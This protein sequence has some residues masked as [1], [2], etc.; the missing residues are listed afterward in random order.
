MA[1]IKAL[2]ELAGIQP[3]YTDVFGVVHEVPESTLLTL[4]SA[5]GVEAQDEQTRMA[6][7]YALLGYANRPLPPVKILPQLRLRRIAVPGVV[8]WT[9]T[10]EED[11]AQTH[12]A[13]RGEIVLPPLRMGYY[14]LEARLQTGETYRSR[15]IVTPEYCWL[16]D[17]MHEGK[18]LWGLAAQLYGVRSENN[19][20]LGDFSDLTALAER[21][22]EAGADLVGINPIHAMYPCNEYHFSP[23]SPSSRLYINSLYIDPR[24][25][26]GFDTCAEAQRIWNDPEFQ[27]RLASVRAAELV[28][29]PEIARL[30]YWLLEALYRHFQQHGEREKFDAYCEEQGEL[31]TDQALF[32]A[33]NEH[34]ASQAGQFKCWWEWPEDYRSA[35]GEAAQTFA[36]DHAGRLEYFRW[37][38]WVA[39]S[40]MRNAQQTARKN[41]M[42]LGL[43]RDLAVGSDQAGAEVWL[44][45]DR[46]IRGVAVGAPPDR[47]NPKGQNW[48]LPP[49]N[50]INLREQGYR[51]FIQLV[52]ANM[53]HCRALR[54][55]HAFG[56]ARLFLIPN[57]ESPRNGAYMLFNFEEM[58]AVLRLESHR[59]KCV[60]IGEDLGTF[61]PNYKDG[62]AA[63]GLLSYRLLY[64]ERTEEQF[65]PPG[66]YPALALAT[67]STHDLPTL[68]GW[69]QEADL[70]EREELQLYPTQEM[71]EAARD[72]RRRTIP[73][74]QK[75]LAKENLAEADAEPELA[76]VQ[77]YLARSPAGIIMMQLE[78]LL[79]VVRQA[80][81]PATT[82]QRPNWRMRL[83]VDLD[84]I[85]SPKGALTPI[86]RTLNEER[87]RPLMEIPRATYRLQFHKD[88]T[89]AD[90]AT[91]VPYLAA[92]GISH[93]YASPYFAARPGSTHG[94]DITDHNRFNEELGGEAGYRLFADT[95]KAHG[96]GQV[97]D[98]VPNH[99]GIGPDNAAWVS[100]LEW[101]RQSPTASM[102]DIDWKPRSVSGAAKLIVPA[103]GSHYGEALDKGEFT[104]VFDAEKGSFFVHYLETPFPLCPA[105]YATIH[106]DLHTVAAVEEGEAL[107]R[108]LVE[109]TSV[110]PAI[111]AS[112]AAINAD[113][114]KLHDLLERQH[115]RLA[116]WRVASSEVNYRRFFDINELAGLRTEDPKV[117]AQ[118]HQK[119]LKLIAEGEVQGLRIDHIDGLA[120]PEAYVRRLKDTAGSGL[121]V[122]VEKILAAH[123][124]LREDWRVEGTSGYDVLNQINALFVPPESES[125]FDRI[126]RR[127]TGID[128]TFGETVL[129]GKRLI[130]ETSLASELNVLTLGLKRLA[131]RDPHSRDYTLDG[132]KEALKD[133]IAY[134]PTYR[135]Y[136]TAKRFSEQDQKGLDWA[137]GRAKRHSLLPDRT[138]YDFIGTLLA[139]EPDAPDDEA[140]TFVRRFQQL[141]G[142][143]MAKGLEDTSFYRYF[144]LLSLNEVGGDASKFGTSAA[145]FHR[146]QQ[147]RAAR[148]PGTMLATATHDTKRGEDARARLNALAENPR[149]WLRH[150]R[151]WSLL[152]RPYKTER[153]GEIIPSANEEYFIYQTLLGSWPVECLQELQPKAMA[154]YLQRL[155]EYLVKALREGKRHSSWSNPDEEYE[156]M[157]HAYLRGALGNGKTNPFLVGFLPFVQERAEDGVRFSLAQTTLKLT[158]P[159]VPDIYQGTERWDLSLVDPDNRRPVDYAQRAAALNGSNPSEMLT[160]W[161]DGRIKQY[162]IATLLKHRAAHPALYAQGSYTPLSEGMND[163]RYIGFERSFADERLIVIVPIRASIDQAD[164][165]T[166]IE[167][168]ANSYRNLLTGETV[169][170]GKMK[171][172]D[173]NKKF[174]CVVLSNT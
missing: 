173:L 94:Y 27:S 169:Q 110:H 105:D 43:Y 66:R 2:A 35:R 145:A 54:I 153:D 77:S 1:E 59:N 132:F 26:E 155:E 128:E 31:L 139:L 157:V 117:F 166:E 106:A 16:P 80:N 142:P 101:G 5:I 49:L 150:L 114:G 36:R 137:T 76:A 120:D 61:P 116:Y 152:T 98:F 89:F 143:V 39:D 138:I 29:Y 84:A 71:A 73:G 144:R 136:G 7:A 78:D 168:P 33:L 34:F 62:A 81:I 57:G 130:L 52:R 42:V 112:V 170:G 9:L 14:D 18:R 67:L 90:A 134:Y 141:S 103:L 45:P 87:A 55:D 174:G 75:A 41:G 47:R 104:L 32:D 107:K 28:E 124:A 95:L 97:L 38:Q 25:V 40:Q 30:K 10:D 82:T 135:G 122:T 171:L 160:H 131:D 37:L 64:F 53:R 44:E 149:D 109:D 68:K 154:A 83:P 17:E 96:L 58:L 88:F 129:E 20:G 164:M 19:M 24:A 85:L 72:E 167:L 140:L 60:V 161:Q 125:A 46:F 133:I 172:A 15:L 22:G 162:V 121:Y 11:N 148:W 70:V 119:V 91:I 4:L 159:G 56:L 8:E 79:G 93:V 100:V 50:P 86:A 113:H 102:F 158:L 12:P 92:L 23:Y 115:Y 69:L 151:R 74:L 21:A 6:S 108:R 123:E 51:P 111:Q 118:M 127:F 48:G 156:A 165:V 147:K 63:S 99:M 146:I 163:S 13:S 65:T 3:R 126:Y